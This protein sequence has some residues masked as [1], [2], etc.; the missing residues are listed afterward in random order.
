M[1][2]K[3]GVENCEDCEKPCSG[4]KILCNTRM[5]IQKTGFKFL[6][7]LKFV[8]FSE[9]ENKENFN[10]VLLRCKRKYE[11]EPETTTVQTTVF[12]GKNIFLK[13]IEAYETSI[14][15]FK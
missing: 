8:F 13:V 9:K 11:P 14:V 2:V 3:T 4:K 1:W 10:D 5:F 12:V 15:V 6:D 7:F